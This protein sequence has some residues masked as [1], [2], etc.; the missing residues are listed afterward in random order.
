MIIVYGDLVDLLEEAVVNFL[1]VGGSG[2]KRL[3][4]GI[5]VRG[6]C[7]GGDKRE[8]QVNPMF[9]AGLLSRMAR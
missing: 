8:G 3:G 7:Q 6:D 5:G 4:L 2:G 1:D 9:H